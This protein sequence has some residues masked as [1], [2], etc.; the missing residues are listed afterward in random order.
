MYDI[1]TGARA[2]IER[3][4]LLNELLEVGD[5]IKA[6]VRYNEGIYVVDKIMFINGEDFNSYRSKFVNK[7]YAVISNDEIPFAQTM[8]TVGRRNLYKLE[9]ELFETDNLEKLLNFCNKKGYVLIVLAVNTSFENKFVS[10]YGTDNEMNY[11]KIMSAINYAENLVDRG[12]KVV[13]FTADIVEII[14]CLNK[15]FAKEINNSEN[16]EETTLLVIQKLLKFA[17]AY[18]YGCSGTLILCYDEVDSNNNFF[19]NDIFKISKKLN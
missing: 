16:H 8:A 12:N 14:K 17:R 2:R 5:K 9:N 3:T 4:E 7:E 19:V 6:S 1:K 18:N 10:A 11:H 15:F 13:L